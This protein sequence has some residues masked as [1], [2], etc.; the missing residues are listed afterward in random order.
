M[1]CLRFPPSFRCQNEM[2]NNSFFKHRF[3]AISLHWEMRRLHAKERESLLAAKHVCVRH[4]TGERK[5]GKKREKKRERKERKTGKEKRERGKKEREE[6]NGKKER[7]IAKKRIERKKR[8]AVGNSNTT[9]INNTSSSFPSSHVLLLHDDKFE[10]TSRTKKPNFFSHLNT[11]FFSFLFQ[12][13]LAK[14][15]KK[16]QQQKVVEKILHGRTGFVF[17]QFEFEPNS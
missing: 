10:A 13:L 2:S 15:R 11:N 6:K 7:T 5:R 14:R 12:T 4:G 17:K 8:D 1:I 3:E 16:R 9:H